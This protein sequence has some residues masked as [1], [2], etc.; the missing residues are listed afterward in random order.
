VLVDLVSLTYQSN[1]YIYASL[2]C[3]KLN[4]H[5]LCNCDWKKG[6]YACIFVIYFLLLLMEVQMKS[7][8]CHVSATQNKKAIC[9]RNN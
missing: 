2:C 6:L 3:Y 5:W 9:C 1:W 8:F 4:K 7:L